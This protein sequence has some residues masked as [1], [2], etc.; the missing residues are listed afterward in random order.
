MNKLI[1]I[2]VIVIIFLCLIK[3]FKFPDSS[4]CIP[5]TSNNNCLVSCDQI[6]DKCYEECKGNSD[7]I[8]QCYQTK[9]SCYIQC[10]GSQTENFCQSNPDCGCK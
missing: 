9:G 1:Y 3:C 5:S 2:I 7:C 8:R 6:S 10:L 4:L